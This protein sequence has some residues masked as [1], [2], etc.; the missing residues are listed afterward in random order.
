MK[1][2]HNK[3]GSRILI[4]ALVFFLFMGLVKTPSLHARRAI[5]ERALYKCAV[6]A[7]IAGMSGGPLALALWGTGC[8]MGYDFCLKY[9]DG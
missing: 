4:A 1:K 6:D 5:C 8:L 2:I 3:K 9:Y 7:V